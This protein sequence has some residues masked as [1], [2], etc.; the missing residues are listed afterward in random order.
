MLEEPHSEWITSVVVAAPVSY[1]FRY[2][3]YFTTPTATPRSLT[4][5]IYR[6][7]YCRYFA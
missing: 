3:R 7:Y 4:A 1:C 6:N 5:V 2:Y